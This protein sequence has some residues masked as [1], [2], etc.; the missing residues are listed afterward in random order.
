MAHPLKSVGGERPFWERGGGWHAQQLEVRDPHRVCSRSGG[1]R[2]PREHLMR[3]VLPPGISFATCSG[4]RFSTRTFAP[5]IIQAA[6]L[7]SGKGL[8]LTPAEGY[9][10][11]SLRGLGDRVRTLVPETD[12]SASISSA[13]V[14]AREGEE[15]TRLAALRLCQSSPA[16]IRLSTNILETPGSR[17]Q[18][19]TVSTPPDPRRSATAAW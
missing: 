18:A 5:A 7:V 12:Q 15:L 16:M 3:M 1:A 4:I 13:P 8:L 2:C 19:V 6:L 9:V 17:M 10:Y 11:V 14:A